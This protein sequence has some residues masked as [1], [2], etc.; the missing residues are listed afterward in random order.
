[1]IKRTI[2]ARLLQAHLLAT[3][4]A[5][6][7]RVKQQMEQFGYTAE[8]MQEV[9]DL[10]RQAEALKAEKKNH[11][12]QKYALAKQMKDD[13]NAL[14]ALYME[15]LNIARFA[16]RKDA[17]MQDQLELKGLRKKDW[18]GWLAQVISFYTRVEAKGLAVMKRN[19]APA[20]EI[21]QGKA[22]AE[23]LMAAY[24][25]K[26]SNA[27]DAQSATQKR[28]AVLRALDRWVSDFKKIAQVALQDDPQLLEVLGIMVPSVR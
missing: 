16:F 21:V 13:V 11:Y 19:G 28:D 2:E 25:N 14:K 26:K 1:M 7:P 23:A 24:Q 10:L 18:A 20:E 27:G 5:N 3:N 17:Y 8:R 9:Y 12:S 22:M 4:V 15:H 6:H